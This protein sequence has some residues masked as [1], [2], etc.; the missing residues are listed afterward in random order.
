VRE[1]KVDIVIP[2]Y[3]V[4][5]KIISV[6]HSIPGF[7]R[8][9]Y[10]VDDC[11]PNQDL[12]E[13]CSNYHDIRVQYLYNST[14]LG[15]GGATLRGMNAAFKNG[16][17]IVI[18]IDGDGQM[19]PKLLHN[20]IDPIKHGTADYVKGNRFNSIEAIKLMPINRIFL[21]LIVTIFSKIS[22]GYWNILDPTNG[23]ISIS[24]ETFERLNIKNI[25]NR[26]FFESDMLLNL[27]LISAVVI[28]FP[29]K[30]LYFDE[31]SNI[32]VLENIF[33]FS[34]G[35]LKNLITRLFFI[36]ILRDFGFAA[37]Y[38]IFSVTL[39]SLGVIFGLSQWIHYYQLN[40]QASAGT[41]ML[42]A[43]PVILGLQLFIAFLAIDFQN[44]PKT[45]ITKKLL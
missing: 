36:Y 18:K 4:S 26:Y 43:L 9:I 11:C 27:Y 38:L 30:A 42:C 14:N 2:C 5:D 44:I 45:P 37:L 24:S 31:K 16:A 1:I 32:K 23:Y 33:V 29:I 25:S 22:S 21:N 34:Y 41:V 8:A 17:D 6:L 28:D 15:V 10:I 3:K 39:I 13:I 40:V 35:Y 20:F 12:K 19:D 7:C